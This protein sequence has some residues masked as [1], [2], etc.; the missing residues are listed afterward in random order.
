MKENAMKTQL[1]Q[2]KH[3]TAVGTN[4]I[5]RSHLEKMAAITCKIS[6]LPFVN[7]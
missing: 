6:D 1:Q 2:L 7:C 3:I 4:N 5:K